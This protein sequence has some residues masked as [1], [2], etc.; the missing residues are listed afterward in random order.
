[1][2]VLDDIKVLDLTTF[3]T[4]S[5]AVMYLVDMGA[6]AIKIEQPRPG[7]GARASGTATGGTPDVDEKKRREIAAAYQFDERGKRR[8]CLN[9]KTQQGKDIFYKLAKTADIVVDEFRPGVTKRLGIDYD[10]LSATNPRIIC[11]SV[12]GYGHDGPYSFRPGHDTNYISVAGILGIT[13]TSDGQHAIPGIPIGDLAGGAMQAT[14]GILLALIA[15]ERTGRGQFI[16]VSMVDAL[17]LF[18]MIRHGPD[19]FKSGRQPKLG[20]RPSFV[21]QTKDR[22]YVNVA[23]GEPWFWE[24]LCRA[25]GMEEFVPYQR[26]AGF[27]APETQDMLEKREQIFS[28]FQKAFLTKTR[29]EWVRILCEADTCVGPVNRLD[30]VL[31][32]PHLIHRKTIVEIEHPSLG[33]IKYPGVGIKLSETPGRI[34]GLPAL[35]GQHTDEILKSVGYDEEEIAALREM[36]AIS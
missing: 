8:I 21:F 4:G 7:F 25:L 17:A 3:P 15:R 10:T 13:G 34:K 16:D 23:P 11:C 5:V 33:K 30:E 32:D 22:Q 29:D 35:P 14:I 28:S 12:T 1:M 2:L 26:A 36:E 6:D 19:F 20:E 24:R 9:L 27:F 31:S 18:M